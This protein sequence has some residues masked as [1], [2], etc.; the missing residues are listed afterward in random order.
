MRALLFPCALM[1]ALA[2][3]LAAQ[4]GRFLKVD[5]IEKSMHHGG[6]HHQDGPN[7]IH[8]RVPVALAKGILEAANTHGDIKINGENRGDIH[9]DQLV[10]LLESAKP[11][12]LLVEITSDKGD[13][14]K[15]AVE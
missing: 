15:V 4:N 3:P 2:L 7:Q 5:I 9:L 14:V 8:I 10:K 11:G 12:D 13:L 6:R 1:G